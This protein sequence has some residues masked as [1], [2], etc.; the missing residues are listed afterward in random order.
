MLGLVTWRVLEPGRSFFAGR[1]C[2][3]L[4]RS[5]ETGW[6]TVLTSHRVGQTTPVLTRKDFLG[7]FELT[8]YGWKEGATHKFYGPNNVPDLACEE[9]SAAA[10]G[11]LDGQTGGNWRLRDAVLTLAGEHVLDLFGGSGSTLIAAEHES[12]GVSDGTGSTLLRCYAWIAFSEFSGKPAV[13]QRTGESPIP[14]K[15]REENMR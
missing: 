10:N 4:S 9:N 2:K 8:F 14:M 1:I 7:C 13:L 3:Q 12:Q 5:L 15:A 11:T 6:I